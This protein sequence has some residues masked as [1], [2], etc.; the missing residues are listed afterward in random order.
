MN[1][2]LQSSSG[3]GRQSIDIHVILPTP[4]ISP[5]SS[6][7][8]RAEQ[9]LPGPS[10]YAAP[11]LIH[12]LP[13][14]HYYYL[15][16]RRRSSASSSNT[17]WTGGNSPF[18]GSPFTFPDNLK[19]VDDTS[20]EN[21]PGGRDDDDGLDDQGSVGSDSVFACCEP[22]PPPLPPKNSASRR[23]SAC[24]SSYSGLAEEEWRVMLTKAR[25]QV[26]HRDSFASDLES[27]N[28]YLEGGSGAGSGAGSRRRSS[29]TQTTLS[30]LQHCLGI[31]TRSPSPRLSPA[32]VPFSQHFMSL[33]QSPV[34]FLAAP[35]T[36]G[37]GNMSPRVK[38]GRKRSVDALLLGRTREQQQQL[39][40]IQMQRFSGPVSPSL[41]QD[42]RRFQGAERFS[43]QQ[44]EEHFGIGE[45]SK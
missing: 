21:I 7:H 37:G 13:Q 17:T 16:D 42:G 23:A 20:S 44:K 6:E 5:S 8:F 41:G 10:S 27:V 19:Y 40:Q 38:G 14:Q 26:H 28:D 31:A 9:P 18:T 25:V 34:Q 32:P 29:S 30:D 3:G 2:Y 15:N 35:P 4:T 39:Q 43:R 36:G 12:H 22:P 33:R 45:P 1:R 11:Q 24:P